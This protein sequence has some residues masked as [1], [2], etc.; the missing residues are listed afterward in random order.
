MEVNDIGKVIHRCV[1]KSMWVFML[2]GQINRTEV[3][4]VTRDHEFM[5]QLEIVVKIVMW[6]MFPP[7]F[8]VKSG[9]WR[10]GHKMASRCF[11][12]CW[13]WAASSLKQSHRHSTGHNSHYC[14]AGIWEGEKFVH[15][16]KLWILSIKSHW[17]KQN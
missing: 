14:A 16:R 7:W 3:P 5:T 6:I 1:K 9:S 4:R 15:R 2:Y 12:K 11:Q 13:P 10:L 8:F 17:I